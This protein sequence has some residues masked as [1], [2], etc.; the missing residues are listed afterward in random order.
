VAGAIKKPQVI[1]PPRLERDLLPI[2]SV[3]RSID[4][5]AGSVASV[6]DGVHADPGIGGR[7]PPSLAALESSVLQARKTVFQSQVLTRP[8]YL[9]LRTYDALRFG[10]VWIGFESFVGIAIETRRSDDLQALLVRILD[11]FTQK[12]LVLNGPRLV[13]EVIPSTVPENGARV[14]GSGRLV[15]QGTALGRILAIDVVAVVPIPEFGVSPR[16]GYVGGRMMAKD[17]RDAGGRDE[18]RPPAKD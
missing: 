17:K 12:L 7:K 5:H 15:D 16:T 1:L 18:Q 6:R 14:A 13:P 10:P 11:R 9:E 8:V 4:N 3:S 2:S